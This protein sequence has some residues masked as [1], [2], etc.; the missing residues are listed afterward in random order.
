[1]KVINLLM[2]AGRSQG[3]GLCDGFL[4]LLCKLVEIHKIIAFP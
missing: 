3:L 1:M 4:Q 2:S